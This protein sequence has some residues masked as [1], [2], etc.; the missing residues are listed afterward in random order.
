MRDK[1]TNS[2]GTSAESVAPFLQPSSIAVIGASTDESRI[3]GQPIAYLRR[4][5]F[6]GAI[7]PVN[8]GRETVQGLRC[9]PSVAAIDAPVD[10]ALVVVNAGR[11]VEAVQDCAYAGTRAVS[12]FT[13]GFAEI[14]DEG[15]HAQEQMSKIARAAGMRLCGPNCAGMLNPHT[16]LA[17][18]FGSHIREDGRL[19]PGSIAIATQ[20]GAV[21]AYAFCLMRQKGIGLSAW[22]STGNEADVE[23]A[24]I[25]EYLAYE[26]RTKVIGIYL[27]QV[28]SGD[29]LMRAAEAAYRA[30]KPIVAIKVGRTEAGRKAAF[31][32]TAALAG[33]AEVSS[34]A[35]DDLGIAEVASTDEFIDVVSALSRRRAGR[36][37]GILSYSGGIGIIAA[38]RCVERGLDVPQLSDEFAAMLSDALPYA[39]AINPVDITGNVTNTPEHYQTALEGLLGEPSVDTVVTFLGH[40][41]LA[42]ATGQRFLAETAQVAESLPDGKHL[43]VVAMDDPGGH[44]RSVCASAELPLFEDMVRCVDAIDVVSR[45]HQKLAADASRIW[46][47]RGAGLCGLNG[48]GA[49]RQMS[50]SSLAEVLAQAGVPRPTERLAHSA[51]EARDIVGE[52]SGRAVLKIASEQIVHK[53]D[54]GGV[55]LVEPSSDPG[56]A[57]EEMMLRV[58]DARPDAVIEGVLVQEQIPAGVEVLVG[59]THDEVFG[60]AVTVGVGGTLVELVRDVATALAPVDRDGAAALLDRT[61]VRQLLAGL[62]GGPPVDVEALI[63][64]VVSLSEVAWERRDV[65]ASLE[66]N[67][68]IVHEQGA[69]AVDV[70]GEEFAHADAE[71]GG[72][73]GR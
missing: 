15:R 10:L 24:D 26:E 17:A 46:D 43:W 45:V 69:A 54:V 57:Y 7:Y 40:L 3:G 42:A 61:V 52:L 68:V 19:L 49:R 11:A 56:A 62:R 66:V 9:F 51:A 60:P 29:K 22:V 67:P 12:V 41:P 5:G 65:L 55:V 20:S 8:P 50:A 32:H 33:D 70:I 25:V 30:G 28:R 63:S 31:S 18:T 6:A 48:N 37:V 38:D 13:A 23:V 72:L 4:A 36:R 16:R 27:E 34:A 71:T 53:S 59:I 14:G 39:S 35:L 1:P 64:I 44:S 2:G 73:H 58:R 47:R 21:G